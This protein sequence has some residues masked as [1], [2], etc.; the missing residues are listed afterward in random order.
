MRFL[1]TIL[2]LTVPDYVHYE[3]TLHGNRKAFKN[4][5]EDTHNVYN[6]EL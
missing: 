4:C 1:K 6:E 2:N 5:N 3:D